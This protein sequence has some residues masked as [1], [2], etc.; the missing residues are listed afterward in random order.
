MTTARAAIGALAAI[1]SAAPP[2]SAAERH[3]IDSG[4]LLIP[5]RKKP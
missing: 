3:A 4:D 5:R 1:L 2:A